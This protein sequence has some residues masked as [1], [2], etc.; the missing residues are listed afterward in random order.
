MPITPIFI[1]MSAMLKIGKL[2]KVNSIKSRT[3]PKINLSAKLPKIPALK[4]D[5]KKKS[6][7]GMFSMFLATMR[8]PIK[9]IMKDITIKNVVESC[10]MLNAAPV[11]ST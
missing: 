2:I 10:K 1:N 8:K 11:F 4:I 7:N 9:R 6:L 5:R 3:C